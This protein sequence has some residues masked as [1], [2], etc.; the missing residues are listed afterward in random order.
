MKKNHGGV[1]LL[2]KLQANHKLLKNQW[3]F[4]ITAYVNVNMLKNV[5]DE[6]FKEMA[7]IYGRIIAMSNKV[8]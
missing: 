2:V 3:L 8:F 5:H 1:L 4:H 6:D 7:I